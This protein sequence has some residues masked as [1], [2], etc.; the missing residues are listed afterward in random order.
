MFRSRLEL[1]DSDDMIQ[2]SGHAPTPDPRTSARSSHVDCLGSDRPRRKWGAGTVSA[3]VC[4]AV[5][6]AGATALLA[7]LS[8]SDV[9]GAAPLG[10]GA[11]GVG[12]GQ[13]STVHGIAADSAGQVYV[14][15]GESA[16]SSEGRVQK[17]SP[18]GEFVAQWGSRG[19][20]N[21]QFIQPVQVAIDAND[22]VYVVDPGSSASRSSQARER[23]CWRSAPTWEAQVVSVIP[24]A[25]R[26]RPMETPCTSA[27]GR[28][29]W[30]RSRPR[31]R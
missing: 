8:V 9:A 25:S 6:V 14:T 30:R 12:P 22:N 1:A 21:G 2:R 17:F 10:W 31:G 4:R 20:G 23:S 15:D 13:F 26:C 3:S 18:T 16:G 27:R 7:A 24:T 11:P 5:V 19:S 29:R 28:I